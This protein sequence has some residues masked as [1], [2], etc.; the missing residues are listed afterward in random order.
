MKQIASSEDILD[1]MK[2]L[3]LKQK[4]IEIL[5]QSY[6]EVEKG[7]HLIPISCE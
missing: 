2:T 1:F 7:W 6:T 5:E 3:L 4:F